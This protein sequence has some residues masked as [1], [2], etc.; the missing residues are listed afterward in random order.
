MKGCVIVLSQCNVHGRGTSAVVELR[1]VCV[2]VEL[3]DNHCYLCTTL[4]EHQQHQVRVRANKMS[5]LVCLYT[6]HVHQGGSNVRVVNT[7]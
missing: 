2:C 1:C 5:S 4:E 7:I 3:A 6:W